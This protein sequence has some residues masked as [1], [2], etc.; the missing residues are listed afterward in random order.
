M[1]F[2]IAIVLFTKKDTTLPEKSR[3]GKKACE[4]RKQIEGEHIKPEMGVQEETINKDIT[5]TLRTENNADKLN[6]MSE[7]TQ[8]RMKKRSVLKE[9]KNGIYFLS[10]QIKRVGVF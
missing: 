10:L 6:H 8:N 3:S 7:I 2:K 9:N 1:N 5:Q 4:D